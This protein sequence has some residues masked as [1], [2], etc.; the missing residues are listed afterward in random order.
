MNKQRIF[1]H[2]AALAALALLLGLTGCL[3][4]MPE[5]QSAA[6]VPTAAAPP[7]QVSP[8]ATAAPPSPVSPLATPTRPSPAPTDDDVMPTPAPTTTL[9]PFPTP[10][11]TPIVTPIPT[12]A[13]PIIPLPSGQASKLYTLVFRDGNVIR[14][15]NSDGTNERTLVDI[16]A[17]LPLFLTIRL[18][19]ESV[20]V[21]LDK[22]GSPSPDGSQLALMLSN[23]ES[24]QS[25]SKGEE[26]EFSIYLFDIPTG[27]LRLLV[28]DGVEP[29]WSPDGARI[30]Y[31]S[32][33]T[34]GLWI[35]DV[36]TGKTREI[37]AVD[38]KKERF[39]S[40]IDWSPD[41][42]RIVFLD[43]A[44]RQF[45]NIMVIHTDGTSTATVVVPWEGYWLSWP[46]WSP[47]GDKLLFISMGGKSSS[48]QYFYNLWVMNPDGTGQTQLTQDMEV[49]R[50]RWSPDGH[51]IAFGGLIAYEK[52]T[53]RYD[54]WLVDRT[55]GVLKRLTSDTVN[56]TSEAMP[57]W[58]PD[59]SRIFFVRG[60]S[61]TRGEYEVW[62]ISL[63]DGTQTKLP[64][65]VTS[66]FF[67]LR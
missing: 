66:D 55:R 65:S 32:T 26:P 30:A 63:A 3:P 37:H 28:R 61:L 4:E 64:S 29:V 31:R 50:A 46:Q 67:V 21:D 14:A 25:L 16:R 36:A 57:A 9:P 51:W 24:W 52:P 43:G 34:S 44:F 47:D 17:H 22:W 48:S 19:G 49:F 45:Y 58:S 5:P 18:V 13:P 20:K 7:S 15:I 10:L 6:Q 8:Q 62:T 53:P 11:P 40:E 56:K 38:Q 41:G 59:G 27:G 35:V 23:V 1:N 33:K 2:V 42:K 12:V 54:L 60:K 39:V